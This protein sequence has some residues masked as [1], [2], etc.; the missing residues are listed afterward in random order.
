MANTAMARVTGGVLNVTTRNGVSR[1]TK[2]PYSMTIV[3]V[4]V[5]ER[6][7]TELIL[8]RDWQHEHPRHGD[9]LDLVVEF[10]ARGNGALGTTI[11]DIWREAP[12]L[13]TAG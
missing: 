9:W 11:L 10:S 13:A 4:L 1:A 5:A 2:E 8:P 12:V 7:V 3:T 6:G